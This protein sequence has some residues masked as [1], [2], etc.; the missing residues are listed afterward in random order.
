MQRKIPTWSAGQGIQNVSWIGLLVPFKW[1]L[2]TWSL[3]LLSPTMSRVPRNLAMLPPN[4]LEF[5]GCPINFG[6]YPNIGT[7]KNMWLSCHTRHQLINIP[8]VPAKGHRQW[9]APSKGTQLQS[10]ANGRKCARKPHHDTMSLMVLNGKPWLFEHDF[11]KFSLQSLKLCWPTNA[12]RWQFA[13]F[14]DN[15]EG[16]RRRQ[17][18]L[19]GSMTGS[20]VGSHQQPGKMRLNGEI[21]W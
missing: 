11:L 17:Q 9:A 15:D 10:W 14:I 7:H 20:F 16:N 19:D 2:H 6:M 12:G 4:L 21:W 13:G 18:V 3:L 1:D 5:W 8:K